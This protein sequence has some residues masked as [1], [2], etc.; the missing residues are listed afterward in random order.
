[1]IS[2]TLREARQ[3]E[4][5]F[6][7]RITKEQRPMFHL[8]PRTGWMNDPNGFTYYQGKYHLFYHY[9]PYDSQWGLMHWGHAVS[10]DLLHWQYAPAAL[11]PDEYYDKDGVW[12]GSAMEMPDGRLLMAYTGMVEMM[13]ENSRKIPRQIQCLAVGDGIDFVKF[14]GNPVITSDM[15]PEDRKSV[16]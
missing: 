11:A 10:V 1:M 2:Q 7:K 15:I 8:T 6:E 12:S 16:V 5:A 9:Y 14:R 4:E 3:A 13:D